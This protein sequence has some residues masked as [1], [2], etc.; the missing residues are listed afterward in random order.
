MRNKKAK[1][2]RRMAYALSPKKRNLLQRRGGVEQYK[3]D[4]P[5]SLYQKMKKELA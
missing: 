1:R 2:L 5:R 3:E 4:S